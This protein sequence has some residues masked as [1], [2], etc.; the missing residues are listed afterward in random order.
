M[1]DITSP[2][3]ML[4]LRLLI[5]LIVL[6]IVEWTGRVKP[7]QPIPIDELEERPIHSRPCCPVEDSLDQILDGC[8]WIFERQHAS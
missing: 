7:F 4:L 6:P 5:Q 2:V 1:D 3:P 8:W